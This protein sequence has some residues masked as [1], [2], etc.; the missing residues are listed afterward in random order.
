MS[1]AK[2]ASLWPH[3]VD[4]VDALAAA[5]R[6]G[7]RTTM[8]AA[9]GTGKTRIG[10]ATVGRLPGSG[11]I[12]VVLPT[13]ELLRQTLPVYLAAAAG[14]ALTVIAMCCDATVTQ[15]HELHD[16]ADQV[17]VSTSAQL[18]ADVAG[19]RKNAAVFSTYM[20]LPVVGEA[21]R[22]GL[23]GWDVAVVDE[24]HRSAGH[25]GG[26]WQIVHDDKHIPAA[27]RIYMTATPKISK[28]KSDDHVSM[29]D[30]TVFGKVSYRLT[31]AQAIELG[32]L[33]DYRIV[34]PVVTSDE[35]HRLTH[36]RNA[37]VQVGG[38][39]M[40]A[41]VVAT[42]I[43]VLKTMAQF[44]ARRAIS[45]H[46][47]VADAQ[48]W[49]A[50]LP[51]TARLMPDR[52]PE[53][54]AGH[55]SG[56][57]PAATRQQ[58]IGRLA[59]PGDHL[60]L[61]SNAKVLTEG[62]DVPAVDAV[63]FTHPRGEIDAVQAVGRALRTG[64]KA[65]KVAT[66][67][68]PLMLAEGQTPQDALS[69]S[70]WEPV[71]QVLSALRDHDERLDTELRER[72]RALADNKT[73]A[74]GR[75]AELPTWLTVTGVNVDADFAAAITVQA[76]RATTSTWDEC[77]G[78]AQA[79]QREHGHLRIPIDH[80]TDTGLALGYWWHRQKQYLQNAPDG[81]ERSQALHK[82]GLSHQRRDEAWMTNYN[83]LKALYEQTGQ[84]RPPVR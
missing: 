74:V 21:H 13:I 12:L 35:V 78:A 17:V 32:L 37:A 36:D 8:V 9:C 72:R 59:E 44:G 40:P 79:F 57:Q 64:G 39:P 7:G 22:L 30:P 50:T 49:A 14:P 84:V 66:I 61:V 45:Y 27:R 16:V 25:A 67:V 31:F 38:R 52:A 20:S 62:I 80:V 56:S 53:V 69:G 70:S 81:D 60:V 18:L 19:S 42:Q 63:V 43:A 10:A 51:A 3:Q 83:I 11:R 48:A 2:G 28:R 1:P 23:A 24:A 77:Y 15:Q 34:V 26:P 71:W 4:A 54:W 29:D 5:V 65:G 73:P 46:P 82:L 41:A 76:V 47:R 68:V 55:V 58:V 6:S 33:A 75:E